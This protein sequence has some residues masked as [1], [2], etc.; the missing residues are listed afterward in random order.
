MKKKRPRTQYVTA[1]WLFLVFVLLPAS[2]GAADAQCP[3]EKTLSRNA[4][5]ALVAAQKQINENNPSN[6]RQTLLKFNQEYPDENHPYV[7]YTLANLLVEKDLLSQALAQYQKTIDMCEGYAP[8]WQNMGKICFDLKKFNQAALAMEKTYELTGR[9]NHLLLFH[10]AVAHISDKKSEKALNHLQF[11][12]SGKAGPPEAGWVKLMAQLSIEQQ[13][14]KKAIAIVENLLDKKNPD[15]CLF[16]VAANLYLHMNKYRK[17][18]EALSVYGML[19]PLAIA[20]QTLLADLYN[21]LGIPFKAA[22]H[23]EKVIEK[24]SEKKTYERLA[25]AWL[26]A[27]KPEKAMR[28]AEQG[29][30]IHPKSQALWKIKAWIHYDNKE[31]HKA[32]QAFLQACVLKKSD[33]KSLFMHGLC[34]CKAGRHEIAKKALE[35]ASCH[36]RY[37]KQALALIRQMEQGAGKS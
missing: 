10:A 30:K 19:C 31:F 3:D 13:Q 17:A 27:C 18:A 29:L 25:S 34:A 35:K 2:T 23:Y 4:R 37:K 33:S 24:K 7:A 9:K 21:N 14:T 36:S 22:L 16:R 11:L 12:T 32:S 26:E 28:A 6:A 5:I 15:A 8:A 1:L 20:E